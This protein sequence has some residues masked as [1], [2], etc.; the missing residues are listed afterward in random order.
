MPSQHAV[1][2][3]LDSCRAR[4]LLAPVML[5]L[6]PRAVKE[7]CTGMADCPAVMWWWTA[8]AVKAVLLAQVLSA[9]AQ[10]SPAVQLA[11]LLTAQALEQG[12]AAQEAPVLVPQSVGAGAGAGCLALQR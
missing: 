7:G 12:P 8:G 9:G 6:S 10:A 4:G 3:S 2:V 5:M 1:P 11:A